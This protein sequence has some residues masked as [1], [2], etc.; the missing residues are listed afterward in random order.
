MLGLYVAIKML[1]DIYI[2]NTKS[3]SEHNL[4]KQARKQYNKPAHEYLQQPV[5]NCQKTGG[6]QDVLPEV[7]G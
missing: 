2:Y 4:E 3:H 5:Y 6:N 1:T 7:N